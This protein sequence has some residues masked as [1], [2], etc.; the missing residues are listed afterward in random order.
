[1]P[2]PKEWK[3]EKGPAGLVDAAAMIDLEE[4]LQRGINAKN[5][6]G[7]KGDGVTDDT[8]AIQSAINALPVEGGTIFFPHG[9]YN[10][11]QLDLKER[12][13][14][15]LLGV[16]GRSS[17]ATQATVLNCTRSDAVSSVLGKGTSAL[18]LS[19]IAVISSVE[20]Y[21]GALLDFSGKEA[22]Y[23]A[24]EN[25]HFIGKASATLCNVDKMT[26]SLFDHC[27]FGGGKVQIAG[28]SEEASFANCIGFDHCTFKECSEMPVR[29]PG[30][31]WEFNNCAWEPLASGK[32]AAIE[33][34]LKAEGLGLIGCWFGDGKKTG[35]WVKFNGYG[36]SVTGGCEIGTGIVAINVSATSIGFQVVGNKF[37]SCGTAINLEKGCEGALIGAN[38]Y[39][40]CTTRINI[41]GELP[42]GVVH[43]LDDEINAVSLRDLTFNGDNKTRLYRRAAGVVNCVG[44]LEAAGAMRVH[45]GGGEAITLAEAFIF[46]DGTNAAQNLY[47]DA[48]GAAT[49]K[50]NTRGLSTGGTEIEKT[51]G[52]VGFYGHA[53]ASRPNVKPA[54]EVTAKELCEALEA[55]GLVE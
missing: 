49:V 13:C 25:C 53:P 33:C 42:R 18:S 14:V 26:I 21:T 50:V 12:R 5:D 1:M 6:Y 39:L 24:A 47:L 43:L 38:E 30:E 15:T 10:Y 7:A 45:R 55:L 37:E 27:T 8:A 51:G 46:A 23:F 41:N 52:K 35:T 19:G 2:T 11:T 31:A 54:A 9:I 17:G 36:L 28:V 3:N 34:V 16:G 44:D 4:R 48:K 40:S 29:N 22:A 20:A 32:E